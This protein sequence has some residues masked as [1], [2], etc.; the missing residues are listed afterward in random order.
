MS[1]PG[2]SA[3]A[4][5]LDRL[6][7]GVALVDAQ[8]VLLAA[9]AGFAR[10]LGLGET[11]PPAGT[12]LKD[13][14]A[15]LVEIEP[16]TL[17]N[18]ER[19][20]QIR[21][22][23]DFAFLRLAPGG[24]RVRLVCETLGDER[25]I[26]A[27][28]AL[29]SRQERELQHRAEH[30][31]RLLLESSPVAVAIID[32]ENAGEF[33]Y[34]N[35]RH[36]ELYRLKSGQ[37]LRNAR[38]LYAR[39]EQHDEL[40]RRFAEGLPVRGVEVELRRRDGSS[41]WGVLTWQPMKYEGRPAR[42]SWIYDITARKEAEAAAEEARAQAETANQTKSEF[43][44]NMSHELRTPLNAIIGYA[45]ILQEDAEDEGVSHMLPD[46]KK[47]E[48]A[49]KHLLGLINDILDLSKIEAGRM[50]VY[51]EPVSIPALVED[52]RTMA[53]PLA[54]TNDNR[55]E[56]H[57]ESGIEAFQTDLTK[58]KQS[59]L[60]LL[61]NACKFTKGGRVEL[62][63]AS[64]DGMIE[65]K[66]S[67]TGIG[68]TQ[69][70]LDRLFQPFTQADAS[71]T[72]QFG[73]TGL[74]L[75]IT[76]RFCA[77]LGGSVEVESEAGAGSRF[78]IRLPFQPPA[79][80]DAVP[81][82]TDGRADVTG[83]QTATTV[84]L[85]DDEPQIHE[86]IGTMLTREGYRVVHASSGAEAIVKAT[87]AQPAAVLLDVMMPHVDG[88][89]VLRQ[90]KQN[91]N[92]E[93]IPVLIVSMLDERRLGMS[94]GAAEFLTK[95]VDRK[96]LVAAVRAHAGEARGTVLVV[97]DDPDQRAVLA[98]AI[99]AHGLSVVSVGDG[100][101]ALEFLLREP[102]PAVMILDLLMPEMDGFALL[103][104][105]R[106]NERLRGLRSIVLT[107]KDLTPAER[108]YLLGRG[109]MVITKGPDARETLIQALRG[110]EAAED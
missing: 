109:G 41:F 97:D 26:T 54:S 104:A 57:V 65:F 102:R 108:A 19:I 52:L 20:A 81:G 40:S 50:E 62:A 35:S 4:R 42:V 76:K 45:Q 77:M 15:H 80:L 88:W 59:L 94:L 92:L 9:N 38:D 73:G 83:P 44:A 47:I 49:G 84:L 37:A 93:K 33:L 12:P 39:P 6:A 11:A 63:V 28:T 21:A 8:A 105:V 29:M 48:T 68:M 85:V 61:S 30:E 71:T 87:E 78:I 86:L 107:A 110:S 32:T 106:Q 14:F 74:G 75:A 10:L 34:Q 13:L 67:D 79:A 99:Q 60:N 51:L 82:G 23:D 5:L 31:A 66:V 72:R 95:P 100:K 91:P 7:T 24:V 22:G 96:R 58:L 2:I 25:L 98:E 101:A 43:L 90:M 36:A 56:I 89:T 69:A 64:A 55:L 16:G 3:R 46:L 70:Q 27:D 1:E 103:D 53:T 17:S 18:A